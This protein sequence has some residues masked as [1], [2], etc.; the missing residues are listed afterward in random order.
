MKV[1]FLVGTLDR[2]AKTTGAPFTQA[3]HDL[4]MALAEDNKLDVTVV[5]A[6]SDSRF[7]GREK[8]IKLAD[9]KEERPRVIQEINEADPDIIICFGRAAA[10]SAFG[11]GGI[12]LGDVGRRAH[13]IGDI[14]GR[15]YVVDSLSRALAQD[16]IRDWLHLDVRAAVLGYDGTT[17]GDYEVYQPG[18]PDWNE[19][20]FDM[21]TGM[22]VGFDLETYPGISPWDSG[23]RIRMAMVSAEVGKAYVY[24]LD[25]T[26]QEIPEWMDRMLRDDKI[27]KVGSNI[28]FDYTWLSRFGYT[29]NNMF[30]TSVAEHIINENNPKKGLKDLTFKYLPRLGHY[31]LP[32]HLLV[33]KRGGW[34]HVEDHEMYDYAAADAEASLAAGDKQERL[35]A[36]DGLLGAFSLAMKLYP[37][38]THMQDIGACFDLDKNRE[39]DAVF[40]EH[41]A[42]L[43]QDICRHLGPI[44]PDSTQ[45]L[46]D[47]L[48]STVKNINLKKRDFVRHWN[49]DD[50]DD[51]ES[52]VSTA[53][54]VLVREAHKHPVINTVLEYRRWSKLYSTYVKGARERYLR[55]HGGRAFLHAKYNQN[56]T[57]TN[58]LS[59]SGPNFQNI[60]RKPGPDDPPE[61]NVKSQ[62]VSRFDG[63]MILEA[64]FS[65]IEV[66]MTAWLSKDPALREAIGKSDMHVAT[67]A[68]M[69]Q[70][71]E[72]DVTSEERQHAK[73]VG[74]ATMYGAGANTIG[75]QLGISKEKAKELMAKYFAQFPAL[76]QYIDSIHEQA[77]RDLV[78][79]SPFG[80]K[81]RF[82][83]PDPKPGETTPNWNCWDGWRVLRQ[84]FNFMIQNTAA[85]VTYLALIDLSRILREEGFKSEMF[86]TVH[87]SIVFDVYPGE[88]D[89]LAARVREVMETPPAGYGIDVPIS[90]DLE[91]G[92]SWGEK[93]PLDKK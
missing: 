88:L 81:R 30:D 42:E 66:R 62:F 26:K 6:V 68:L 92:K 15:V 45:Q 21:Y 51:P 33:K 67:A 24:Q 54:S 12:V 32:H 36:K 60:P 46:A 78:V 89:R 91:A 86:G 50:E 20:P 56:V 58:R 53:K 75:R 2:C 83:A 73:T 48:F 5:T 79:Q 70:K 1:V 59:S 39:L 35:L 34:E 52:E 49:D 37:V 10:M 18:D 4:L 9:I 28:A 74:F 16:G 90:V 80:F 63:G 11:K 27:E 3:N 64:D 76:Q 25:P 14:R 47:A 84:A 43:R 22:M 55:K 77:K 41:L 72:A 87:D 7:F 13:S 31:S 29:I 85:C 71:D 40:S 61:L 82:R 38:L 17:F 8:N 69:L 57:D 19:P 65:Q 93:K 44:N 23:A